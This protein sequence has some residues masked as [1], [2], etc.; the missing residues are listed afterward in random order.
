LL[1]ICNMP[2]ASHHPCLCIVVLTHSVAEFYTM[3]FLT[4]LRMGDFAWRTLRAEA[5]EEEE[6]ESEQGKEEEEEEEEE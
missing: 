5:D 2:Y 4:R 1:R 3:G 6:D